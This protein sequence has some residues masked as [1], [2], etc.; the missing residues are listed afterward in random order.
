MSHP[1]STHTEETQHAPIYARDRPLPSRN[2]S[3]A[4]WRVIA[5]AS[6][7]GSL[8]FYDFVIYGI[9]A[10]YIARQFFPALDPYVLADPVVLGAGARLSGPAGRRDRAQRRSATAS[11]GGRC[12]S[13]RC[14]PDHARHDPDRPAC[15]PTRPGGWP[16]RLLLG[17]TAPRARRLSRR[18]AAGRADL[19][20]RGRAATRG[21]RLRRHH[22]VRQRRRSGCDAGQ[23]RHPVRAAAGRRRGLRLAGG[24]PARRLHRL[25]QLPDATIARGVAGVPAH[26]LSCRQPDCS[27]YCA[28]IGSRC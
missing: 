3:R 16:R 21:P 24:L 19:R 27:R 23:P 11:A 14:S 26:A 17:G 22:P 9:F 15:P 18:R 2:L 4:Q 8:E 5:L 13:A 6:L 12:S 25:R 10:Q 20:R 1:T 28:S 7:G